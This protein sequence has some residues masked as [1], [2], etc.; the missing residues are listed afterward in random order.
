MQMMDSKT[1]FFMYLLAQKMINLKLQFMRQYKKMSQKTITMQ[2][3]LL[4]QRN[5]KK[6]VRLKGQRTAK[7]S[8]KK[9]SLVILI[10][11]F[12]MFLKLTAK[13]IRRNTLVYFYSVSLF[14]IITV[15]LLIFIRFSSPSQLKTQVSHSDNLLFGV[16]LFVRL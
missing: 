3:V 16:H 13:Y 1:I 10:Y 2:D 7:L 8:P 6:L 9:V 12:I 15:P 11:M 14:H 5:V 4:N